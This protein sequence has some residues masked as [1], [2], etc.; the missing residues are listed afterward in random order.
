MEVNEM[1]LREE[2]KNLI[3]CDL[4]VNGDFEITNS[5]YISNEILSKIEKRID[6]R[7]QQ[8]DN[9]MVGSR[10][11]DGERVYTIKDSVARSIVELDRIKDM[12]K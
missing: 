1:T 2:I 9:Y 4:N 6:E 12:L 5:D 3:L 11:S 10:P 7:I 8:L